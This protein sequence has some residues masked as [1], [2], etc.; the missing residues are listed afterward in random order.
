MGLL[1]WLVVGLIA[2]WLA[3]QIVRGGGYGL[4]GD[5]IAGVIGALIGG[6]LAGQ[7]FHIANPISGIDVRTIVIATIGAILLLI[8]L[9]M[10][11]R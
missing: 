8:V 3:G 6:Y 4:I 11:R 2:G 9:R 7:L 10:V 1:S 5:I